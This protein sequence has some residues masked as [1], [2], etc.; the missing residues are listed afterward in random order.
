MGLFEYTR[1]RE[2]ARSWE[3]KKIISKPNLMVVAAIL[4]VGMVMV[5]SQPESGTGMPL[6]D[7]PGWKQTHVQ[8]F[9]TPAALG[10][11]GEVYT[12]ELRGYSDLPDSSGVGIYA[13]DSVLSVADGRLDYFLHTEGG[14]P[15]VA[16]VIPFGYAGQTYGRYSIRFRSDS[17]PGYKIAFML[18]P[19]SDRWNEGEIDW[20]EGELNGKMYAASAIKG[21]LDKGGVKFDPPARIYSPTD[22]SDWHVATTEWTPGKVKW[23]WD[24]ILIN[25]TTVP[26]GVPTTNLRWTLQAETRDG[27]SDLPPKPSTA[28]HLEIDWV[29]QYAYTP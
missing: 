14:S 23:F 8:D 7:L 1:S 22:S 20:P 6:G 18:W 16:C 4:A 12:Q 25:R 10:Q 5:V 19:S 15:R 17:L 29:V 3:V 9:S 28:G 11:V 2:R 27:A 24:G 13:P 21:S 26:S